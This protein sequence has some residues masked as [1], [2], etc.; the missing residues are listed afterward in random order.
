[1][2]VT[3]VRVNSSKGDIDEFT[4][5]ILIICHETDQ[6]TVLPSKDEISIL[7]QFF[8]IQT[9]INPFMEWR[10]KRGVEPFK[11]FMDRVFA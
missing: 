6:L 11:K 9:E 2:F 7:A 3:A 4:F 8:T 1:M 10:K 5:Q